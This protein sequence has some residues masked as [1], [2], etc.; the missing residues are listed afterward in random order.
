MRGYQLVI[1]EGKES[2][3][4]NPQHIAKPQMENEFMAPSSILRRRKT[5]LLRASP[6]KAP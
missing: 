1:K 6:V 4:N 2:L 3:Q 5:W